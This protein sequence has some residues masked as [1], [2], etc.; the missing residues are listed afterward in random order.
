MELDLRTE[1]W[2]VK[3]LVKTKLVKLWK[4]RVKILFPIC[5]TRLYVKGKD[6]DSFE[7]TSE[8]W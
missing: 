1:L 8:S 2:A 5:L 3:F 7:K 4:R 6:E